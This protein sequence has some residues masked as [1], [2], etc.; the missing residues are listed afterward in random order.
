[1]NTIERAVREGVEHAFDADEVPFLLSR[2]NTHSEFAETY[3]DNGETK[4]T[5]D[6]LESIVE[7]AVACLIM[8]D[9]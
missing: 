5:R 1:M 3:H 9:A 8:L 6:E 2:I 4:A 7:L